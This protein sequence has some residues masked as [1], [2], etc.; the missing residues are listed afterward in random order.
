VDDVR[1]VG[2]GPH[3]AIGLYGWFGTGQ[4]WGQLPDYVDRSAG[5]WAF[6]DLARLRRPPGRGRGAHRGR[7]GP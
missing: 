1:T 6:P 7:S 2:T 3:R 4:G 5:T